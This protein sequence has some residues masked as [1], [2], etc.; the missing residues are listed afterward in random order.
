MIWSPVCPVFRDDNG[1]LLAKPM[2]ANFITSPAPNFGAI[3]DKNE[4]ELDLVP[5]V[6]KIR[7]ELVLALAAAHG[8]SHL[9]LG[10]WGCGVFRN[11]PKLVA[12]IFAAHLFG[13]WA[14]KFQSVLFSVYDCDPKQMTF[15]AFQEALRLE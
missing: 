8:C 6:L 12:S 14:G 11:D 15:T 10:A 5:G 1:L 7:S 13:L 9:I 3:A 2:V 4:S